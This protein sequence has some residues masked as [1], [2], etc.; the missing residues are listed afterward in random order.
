MKKAVLIVFALFL[1]FLSAGA[2]TLGDKLDE[3]V[4]A[5]SIYPLDIQ[6]EEA[7]FLISS[8]KDS[9]VREFTANHLYQSFRESKIMGVE[10]VAIHIFDNWFSSGK[11]HFESEAD[12]MEASLFA[13]LNR[14]TLIGCKAPSLQLKS[15]DGEDFTFNPGRSVIF[16]YSTDCAKCKLES[17]LCSQVLS[18][19][20]IDFYAICTED[21]I[22]RDFINTHFTCPAIHLWD[23]EGTSEMTGLYG[24][25]QTPRI[26]LTDENGIIIGRGLDSEALETMLDAIFTVPEL[27]YGSSDEAR[28][29]F[30]GLFEYGSDMKE[31]VDIIA[32]G[33]L[34]R[35]GRDMF[36]QMCG[37]LLYFLSSKP[38]DEY[39]DACDYL[40][41][42]HIDGNEIWRNKCDSLKILGLAAMLK[43]LHSRTVIGEKLPDIKVYGQ[44]C[45]KKLDVRKKTYRLSKLPRKQT[46]I[47]FY[48]ENC[49]DCRQR[50]EE[51][52]LYLEKGCRR[53]LL[54]DVDENQEEE[55]LLNAFDL[56]SLP[57]L[58]E[59]SSKGIVL[60]RYLP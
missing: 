32:E 47:I 42:K 29:L 34:K 60:G 35:G 40:I 19:Y 22:N 20:P 16:F 4:S 36:R 27:D 28:N 5:I 2:Q 52:S 30:E 1:G 43:D 13:S 48:T 58:V 38:V 26:F 46:L 37:D 12:M 56:S 11:T 9:I 17:I 49:A 44:L 39:V 7:D 55:E 21:N 10:G 57:H 53:V 14:N 54:V 51:A 41:D 25:I 59:I 18:K 31:T 8:C 6:K 24:I 3:Y 15:L 33:S 45:R 50:L 23:P